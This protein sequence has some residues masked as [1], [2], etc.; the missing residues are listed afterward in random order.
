MQLCF[1]DPRQ[2]DERSPVLNKQVTCMW[3]D[4]P[5][6]RMGHAFTSQYLSMNEDQGGS[7]SEPWGDSDDVLGEFSM[8]NK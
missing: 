8:I 5:A 3:A 7:L 4:A 1:V 2:N 6:Q